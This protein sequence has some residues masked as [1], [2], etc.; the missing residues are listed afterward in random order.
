[1]LTGTV[2]GGAGNL[3]IVTVAVIAV[4]LET[5]PMLCNSK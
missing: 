1:M 3:A 4:P 2:L 5:L